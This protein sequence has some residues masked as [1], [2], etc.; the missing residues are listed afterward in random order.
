MYKLDEYYTKD[1]FGSRMSFKEKVYPE[2]AKVLQDV[3]EPTNCVIDLGCGNGVLGKG[4]TCDYIGIEGSEEGY[5]AC[6]ERGF[7]CN[8]E[9]IRTMK[10][11]T[12][13][14][15]DLVVS[16][17]VAEHLE[18]EY[19]DQF[20]DTL[21][22]LSDTVVLTA[23]N[24]EGFSHFNCQPQKY[25][26]E[27]FVSRGYEMHPLHEKIIKGLMSIIPRQYSYLYTNMMVFKK[28]ER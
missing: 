10:V 27:K 21:C 12:R 15:C 23:S 11:G 17:E 19:A 26:I 20:V 1:Y 5:K 22:Q 2:I 6:K 8:K 4:F 25:W 9:D 14:Y 3:L 24:D 18:E 7:M 28:N 13:R 16:I